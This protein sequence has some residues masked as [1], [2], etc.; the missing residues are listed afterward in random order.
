[1]RNPD[2]E[3]AARSSP[4]ASR[5]RGSAVSWWVGSD[6]GGVHPGDLIHAARHGAAVIPADVL[7]SLRADLRKMQ[8]TEA[9]VLDAARAP[10]FDF[11]ALEKAQT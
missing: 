9:L 10:E 4:P 5:L 3:D 2:D 7:A 6:G 1:M 8:Q 11:D